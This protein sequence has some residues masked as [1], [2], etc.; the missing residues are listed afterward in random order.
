MVFERL[1]GHGATEA[2]R[3][4]RRHQ[5]LTILDAIRERVAH[6]QGQLGPGDRHR[7]GE[8]LESVGEIERRLQNVE[9]QNRSDI[10][11]LPD[12]PIVVPDS[13]E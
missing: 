6:I 12:A 10:P 11:K 2:E 3:N 4:V 9:R 5:D 1:F 8:Y 13:F 7:L